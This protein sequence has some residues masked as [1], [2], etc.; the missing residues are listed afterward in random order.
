MVTSAERMRSTRRAP[1]RRTDRRHPAALRF[2]G[3]VRDWSCAVGAAM[4]GE[5]GMVGIEGC[6]REK[7]V[8]EVL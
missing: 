4:K 6:S 1:I 8:F 7:Q 5:V 3:M 2:M